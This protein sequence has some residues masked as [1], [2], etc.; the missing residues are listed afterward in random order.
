MALLNLD[1]LV[2]M[3]LH[4][5]TQGSNDMVNAYY[6]PFRHMLNH[7]KKTMKHPH[8]KHLYH[9][10]FIAGLKPNI[11]AEVLL[12]SESLKME[13]MKFNEVLELAKHAEQ[14]INSQLDVKCAMNT[15]GDRK[16]KTKGKSSG[17][18]LSHSVEVSHEKLTPREKD[19][20]TQNIEHCGGMIVNE[21]LH[22]KW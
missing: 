22:K 5:M 19:F 14:T 18:R 3:R 21:G 11:N 12:L 7:Q 2:F 15:S 1:T 10:M 17:K 8:D 20:L 4:V 9:F 6:G 13:D 16:V